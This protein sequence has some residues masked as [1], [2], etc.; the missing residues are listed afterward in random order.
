M[1][2]DNI[3]IILQARMSSERLPGK[4]MKKI[5]GIPMIG[6]QIERLR[7][8][9]IPIVV[10]S[11]ELPENDVLEDYLTSI[12]IPIFRGSELNVLDRFYH[13]AKKYHAEYVIRITGDNPLIDGTFLGNTISG[14]QNF[15]KRSYFSIGRSNTF[16]LGFSFELFSFELLEEAY[17][18]AQSPKE[19]EHVTPYIHQNVPGNIIIKTLY[20]E[21]TRNE[22]R[23]SV[24]TNEDLILVK[25]LI[26]N[27]DCR[28]KPMDEIIDIL[29]KNPELVAINN[30]IT[31]KKWNE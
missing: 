29:D 18:N 31:Q 3:T 13:A 17:N 16:P 5:S 12:E 19:K 14:I 25:T 11:S 26:E 15:G 9:G 8:S 10:A 27:Y 7:K 22:Y 2:K 23:L 20:R 1:V 4:V 24:D 6:I 21:P 28:N 30:R